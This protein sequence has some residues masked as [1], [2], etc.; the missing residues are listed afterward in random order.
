M[1][2][3]RWTVVLFLATAPVCAAAPAASV[4]PAPPEKLAATLRTLLLKN[5][6]DPLIYKEDNWGKKRPGPFGAKIHN[7]G[8]WRKI[9]VTAV[10]P[11]QNLELNIRNVTRPNQ[12]QTRFEAVVALDTIINFEQQIWETGVRLY[13]GSTR[14]RAKVWVVLQCESTLKVIPSK[15]FFPDI[16]F[17]LRATSAQLQYGGLDVEHIAGIGGDGAEVLGKALVSLLKSVKPSLER[18]LLEKGNAAIVKAG[19]TKE[20]RISLT[21]MM[22][23]KKGVSGE[24]FNKLKKK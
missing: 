16:V 4:P 2:K 20:V 12:E 11:A 5:L 21:E 22:Q 10:N 9:R 17:R 14:A 8:V 3:C 6:P 15:G 23:G 1:S 19:D 24:I 7:D 18:D 13:S